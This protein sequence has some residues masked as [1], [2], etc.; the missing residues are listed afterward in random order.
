VGDDSGH[1]CNQY[2]TKDGPRTMGNTLRK[3]F[4]R[5]FGNREMRVRGKDGD[6]TRKRKE[7]DEK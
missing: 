6:A 5:L 7:E 3:A 4:D 2:T 1:T